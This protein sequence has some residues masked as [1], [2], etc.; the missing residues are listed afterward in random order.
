M[1]RNRLLILLAVTLLAILLVVLLGGDDNREPSLEGPLI[2]GL[3]ESVN[4]IEAVDI[5]APGGEVAVSLRRDEARW[6]VAQKDGFEAAFDRVTELLRTLSQARLAA[7]RTAN[8]DWYAR[9]GVQDPGNPDASG[10]RIDFPQRD[11][12]SL[13]VGQTDPTDAGSFVRRAGE[14][15]SWLADAVIEVPV[16][17]VVWLERAIMDI[18]ASE[19]ARIVIR[20]ADGE[21]VRLERA[22]EEGTDFVLLDVPE[23]RSAGQAFRRTAIANGLRALNLDD[24]RRFVPPVPDEATRVLFETVDGLNFVARLFERDGFHWVHFNVSAENPAT[25]PEQGADAGPAANGDAEAPGAADG[26]D[27]DADAHPETA[28]AGGPDPDDPGDAAGGADADA[29]DAAAERLTNAVAV[30]ARLSPWLYRIPQRRYDDLTRRMEDL[31]EPLEDEE[32][33]NGA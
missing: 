31:L 19:I 4:D 18:P 32:A 29:E 20:H 23:G 21:T 17:P 5:V 1:N 16:D 9:L 10:R 6:R 3:A 24:V 14:A 7:P 13:I 28:V 30:D 8:P 25:P 2:P 26:N 15:Q 12:P 33:A 27:S 22:G 11:L